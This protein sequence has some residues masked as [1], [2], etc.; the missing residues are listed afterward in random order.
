MDDLECALGQTLCRRWPCLLLRGLATI[1]M[2]VILAIHPRLPLA[3]LAGL[4][5]MYALLDGGIDGFTAIGGLRNDRAYWLVLF[6]GGLVGVSVGV[7]T[8]MTPVL[9]A[10]AVSFYFAI[11][12]IATGALEMLAAIR[13]REQGQEAQRRILTGVATTRVLIAGIASVGFGALLTASPRSSTFTM[14]WVVSAYAL[15]YGVL[16]VMLALKL[17]GV[18]RQLA[19]A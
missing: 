4:F 17:R 13:V 1:A 5:G 15:C 16:L 11:W 3:G 2:G 6:L 7:M 18:G 10:I 14:L 19:R 12:A 8:L 9:T